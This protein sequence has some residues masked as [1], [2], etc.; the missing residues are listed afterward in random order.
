MLNLEVIGEGAT[1]K[2]YRE[3]EKA[4]KLYV[5]SPSNEVELEAKKQIF[6]IEAGLPVPAI[7]GVRKLSDAVTALDMQYIAG[8]PIMHENM[9]DDEMIEAIAVLV[10]LQ[11]MVHAINATGLTKMQERLARRISHSDRLVMSLKERLLTLLDFLHDGKSSLCHGDFHPGNILYDGQK[12]WL[13]DWV[14]ATAGNP[15]ADACRTYLIFLQY[16]P[17]FSEIYLSCFCREAGIKR[18]DVQIWL[19]IIA[20]ARLEENMDEEK[21][22][23]LLGILDDFQKKSKE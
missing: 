22:I 20:A 16:K 1:T 6:A 11:V 18:D 5:N 2:I 10:K 13:I 9:E 21:R 4:I 12:H 3:G 7:Y 8:Q 23:Q 17:P 14:D 19:P 15:L